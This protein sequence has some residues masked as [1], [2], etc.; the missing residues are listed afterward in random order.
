MDTWKKEAI[1]A[2][3]KDYIKENQL[4]FGAILPI[5]RIIST[6][7]MQGPD[8][9]ATLELLGKE[10]TLLRWDR[11]IEHCKTLVTQV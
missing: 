11:G 4:S 10:E 7:T 8:L 5:L 3:V 1:E 6:G 9:F 2:V